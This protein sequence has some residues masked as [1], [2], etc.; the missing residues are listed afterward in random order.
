MENSLESKH[1]EILKLLRSYCIDYLDDEYLQLCEKLFIKLIEYNKDVFKRGKE[2]TWAASIIWTVGSINFLGDKSI[3]PYASLADVCDHFNSNT[4]T[5]G[6]KASKIRDLL[7]INYF[8]VDYLRDD[9]QISGFLNNLAI[10]Q[11]GLIVPHS[12]FDEKSEHDVIDEDDIYEEE[13]PDHYT[14]IIDA[15]FRTKHAELYQLEYLFKTLLDEDEQFKKIEYVE[16]M[17]IHLSFFGRPHKV[18]LFEK[19]LKSNKFIIVD[20]INQA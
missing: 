4:S 15:K 1:N 20:I 14:I 16:S 9:S 7:D 18:L 2:S 8:N 6:Q 12:W 10:N 5:V 3:E 13:L 17:K 11:D 19:K